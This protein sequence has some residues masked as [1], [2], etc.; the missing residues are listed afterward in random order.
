ML[1][2][3]NINTFILN[4]KIITHASL[5]DINPLDNGDLEEALKLT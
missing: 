1:Y 4:Y 3:W 2:I 5:L